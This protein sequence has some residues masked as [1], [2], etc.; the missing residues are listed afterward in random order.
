MEWFGNCNCL[1]LSCCLKMEVGEGGELVG[2][3]VG[4]NLSGSEMVLNN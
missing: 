3:V 2:I 4:V 1:N